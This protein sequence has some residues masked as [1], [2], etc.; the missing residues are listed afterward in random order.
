VSVK[1]SGGPGPVP[2]EVARKQDAKLK[3]VLA[4]RK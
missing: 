2:L 3:V 1:S 4:S